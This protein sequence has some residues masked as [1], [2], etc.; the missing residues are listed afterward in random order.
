MFEDMKEHELELE[1]FDAMSDR[2][3]L[4]TIW[5]CGDAGDLSPAHG[6]GMLYERYPEEPQFLLLTLY[7]SLAE[8][9]DETLH[10]QLEKLLNTLPDDKHQ[11]LCDLLI[12][13]REKRPEL[14][15]RKEFQEIFV[16]FPD[17]K[18]SESYRRLGDFT[19]A[20]IADLHER[21]LNAQRLGQGSTGQPLEPW[22]DL[23]ARL[24]AAKEQGIVPRPYS[25]REVFDIG[26]VVAH[27]KFGEGL[28]AAKKADK[29]EVEFT[30]R[31]R[32]LIC[33]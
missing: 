18:V 32:K 31:P 15:D 13:L 25:P 6:W 4:Y 11:A 10:R 7:N 20:V 28:V 33:A 23:Q 5:S 8:I 1:F 19:A 21:T 16:D 17:L 22:S 14:E 26:D 2:Q 30:D 24:A 12:Q 3:I 29:I 27:A 9:D